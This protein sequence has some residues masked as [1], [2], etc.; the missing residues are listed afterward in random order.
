SE[1]GAVVPRSFGKK[2][3]QRMSSIPPAERMSSGRTA[4]IQAFSMRGWRVMAGLP[5][6]S[7]ADEGPG[8]R[9]FSPLAGRRCREAAD[10]GRHPADFAPHPA[11]R[12][13]LSPRGGA[14]ELHA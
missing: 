3:V 13:T 2:A 9:A 5:P 6:A 12:A 10:E 8:G 7:A 1:S 4:F 11:L 14:R